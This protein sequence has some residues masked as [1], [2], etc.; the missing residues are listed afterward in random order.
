MSS[1][2]QDILNL[3]QYRLDYQGD[4]YHLI[5]Q[6]IRLI[7]KRLYLFNSGLLKSDLSLAFAG[8]TTYT[9][10]TIS[11]DATV[12][13]NL[14]K[15]S[16]NGFIVAGLTANSQIETTSAINPGP[17]TPVTVAAGTITLLASDVL[18]TEAAG[19]AKTITGLNDYANL[20]ADFWGMSTGEEDD[21]YIDGRQWFL[22]ALPSRQAAILY[23]SSGQP[24][25]Y[26][27]RGTRFYVYPAAD[28]AMTIKGQYF[29]KPSL[30]TA[31]T[32]PIPFNE[33]FDDVIADYTV[34]AYKGEPMKTLQGMIF[35]AVDAITIKRD[36]ATG[37]QPKQVIEWDRMTRGW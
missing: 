33:E 26:E 3:M 32:S 18:T 5:N 20:P 34:A 28:T 7:A 8:P 1:T 25:Y 4:L 6:S 23:P 16:A 13:P 31:V 11:F 10:A 2:V 9:A 29:A 36:K 12:S 37:S 22:M 21:I 14:I 35:D 30:V 24:I 19:V 27:I 17:F 15:D